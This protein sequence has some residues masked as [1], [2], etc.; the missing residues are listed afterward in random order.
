MMALAVALGVKRFL[1]LGD[2]SD[3]DRR[4]FDF[5][6]TIRVIEKELK[7]IKNDLEK[8]GFSW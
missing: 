1:G 5:L 7:Q 4:D 3:Q 2:S 8:I 6:A